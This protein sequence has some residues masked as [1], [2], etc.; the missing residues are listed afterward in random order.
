MPRILR[1]GLESR[2]AGVER[3]DIAN[4]EIS[5][6]Y[7]TGTARQQYDIIVA[8]S[9]FSVRAVDGQ[10][11]LFDAAEAVAALNP[12]DNIAGVSEPL[13]LGERRYRGVVEFIL[14]GTL[15]TAVNSL[16]VEEYLYSVVP[17]EMPQSWHMEALKAQSVAARSYAMTRLHAHIA[18]GYHLC[19]RIHCQSYL[20]A[21]NEAESTTAAVNATA[22]IMAY[23]DELPINAVYS[24][25]N[26]GYSSASEDVWSETVPYLRAVR[27]DFETTGLRWERVFTKRQIRELM[28][29]DIGAVTRVYIS[30]NAPSGRVIELIIEGVYGERVLSKEGIRSFFAGTDGGMLESLNFTLQGARASGATVFVAGADGVSQR[31]LADLQVISSDGAVKPAPATPAVIGANGT[32]TVLM[33]GSGV[34]SGGE[35]KGDAVVLSGRGWGHG[36]GMSQHGARDMAEAGFN[37]VQILKHYYTDIE[38][39]L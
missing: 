5:L 37:F 27:D 32:T 18:A 11:V 6:G 39:G 21:G 24:S 23:Y 10:A 25:S 30:R 22:G 38:V 34:V 35:D 31:P 36:A 19:D 1:I 12:G 13:G 4:K 33:A 15:L 16:T 28:P 2:Y 17:S 20:G 7:G 3:I 26:G 9:G 14:S 29:E 8:T